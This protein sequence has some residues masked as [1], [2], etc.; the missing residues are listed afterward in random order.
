MK[1]V[2]LVF[3]M[4]F[5]VNVMS[6]QTYYVEADGI[7]PVKSGLN[8]KTL[9]KAV[10][11]LYD[12]A[13]VFVEYDEMEDET[14]H[15]VTYYLKGAENLY[16]RA[17]ESGEIFSVKSASKTLRTKS[18]AY[19]GMRAR[20]FIKLPGVKVVF[21]PQADEMYQFLFEIDGVTVNIDTYSYT[22]VG[23]QKKRKALRTRVK[24]K[25]VA[26]DFTPD[27]VIWLGAY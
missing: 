5:I 2:I 21:Q 1:K 14:V 22:S 6:A 15:V 27:A 4:A 7:G 26:A 16:A 9:P 12:K 11:G 10:A 13:S 17:Y 20:D 3:L 19:E 18:G 23:S 25:F 24:P 8:Y